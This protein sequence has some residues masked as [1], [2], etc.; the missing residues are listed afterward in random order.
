MLSFL[1]AILAPGFFVCGTEPR[2]RGRTVATERK[3]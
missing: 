3:V 1:A 2:E